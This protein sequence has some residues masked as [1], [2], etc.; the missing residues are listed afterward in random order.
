ME[1]IFTSYESPPVLSASVLLPAQIL[2]GPHHRVDER[3][4]N[5]GYL[6]HYT[7]HSQFGE[8]SVV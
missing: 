8:F 6:N 7:I 1:C 2:Q 5:D 4:V 3:V